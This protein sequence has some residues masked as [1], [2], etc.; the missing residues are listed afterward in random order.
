M[1]KKKDITEQDFVVQVDKDGNV[2]RVVS[3]GEEIAEEK[4][5]KLP[6]KS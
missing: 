6:E 1:K 2:V 5:E 3:P 4:K